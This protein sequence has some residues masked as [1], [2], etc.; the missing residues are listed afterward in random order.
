MKFFLFILSLIVFFSGVCHPAPPAF[1]VA[2]AVE[3]QTLDPSEAEDFVSLRI[4]LNLGWGLVRFDKNLRPVSALASRW[5]IS[6]DQKTYTFNL[7]KSFWSNGTQIKAQDFIRGLDHTLSPTT[8]ARLASP[9]KDIVSSYRAIGDQ[10][11]EF[12]LRHPAPYFLSLLTSPFSFPQPENTNFK[13]RVGTPT[14]GPYTLQNISE[15]KIVLVPNPRSEEPGQNILEF[16]IIKELSSALA[17]YEKGEIDFIDRVPSSDFDRILGTSGL[18]RDLKKA[19]WLATY[20]IGFNVSRPP[21]SDKNSRLAITKSI[22]R[23]ATIKVLR[24]PQTAASSFVPHPLVSSGEE[25]GP[26]YDPA[27]AQKIWQSSRQ[28]LTHLSLF[29]DAQEKNNLLMTRV[30]SELEENLKIKLDLKGMEWKSYLAFLKDKKNGPDFYRFAW[31]A[32][33]PDPVS[34]LEVFKSDN[35][36]NYSGFKNKKYDELVDKMAQIPDGEQ[37]HRLISKAQKILLTDEVV[38]FPLFHYVQYL[39]I[40]GRWQGLDL[41]PMGVLYFQKAHL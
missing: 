34:H 28:N 20:Y 22:N 10:K 18:A 9:F 5:I 24:D 17:L 40:Q 14:S 37:R 13:I 6:K 3:I 7:K 4:L 11:I 2:M 21:F 27:A 36:N 35:P 1:R 30:Q 19:P 31:L 12:K 8:A 23:A 25:F 41:T 16:R 15:E 33:F 26:S 38:I 39:L 32:P 29:F